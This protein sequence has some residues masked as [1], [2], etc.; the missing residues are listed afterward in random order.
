[1]L[2]HP[3]PGLMFFVALFS[4]SLAFAQSPV[5]STSAITQDKV[6]QVVELQG[7]VKSFQASRSD[8]APNSFK[9]EDAAGTIRV[10]IWPDVFSKIPDKEQITDGAKVR[11]KGKVAEF[12]GA[13]EIHVNSPSDVKIEGAGTSQP[14]QTASPAP[15]SAAQQVKPAVATTAS[16]VTSIAQ[17]TN[18]KVG[19]KFTIQGTV[20]SARRPSSERAPYILK[21]KDATGSIDVVFWQNLADKLSDNQKPNEGDTVRITGTLGEYRGNLQL[22]PET[23]S[24][25]ET[26]KSN[27]ELKSEAPNTATEKNTQAGAPTA[28][29]AEFSSA[30][31]G[32]MIEISGKVVHVERFRLGQNLTITDGKNTWQ[33]I[34][35]ANASSLQPSIERVRGGEDISLRARVQTVEGKKVLVVA[36]PEDILYVG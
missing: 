31:D 5:L 17:L 19:Q 21:V 33:V 18:D 36:S 26:E 28:P 3:I 30:P 35:W 8:R 4:V 23:P 29:A 27:P 9:L 24:D 13:L 20:T 1:M 34:V 25:I 22:K 14:T 15:S 12:R 16:G 11:V 7:T 10:A 2:K 32:S 6:G